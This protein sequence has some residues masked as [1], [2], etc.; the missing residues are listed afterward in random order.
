MYKTVTA[1]SV[2]TFRYDPPM[3]VIAIRHTINFR[4]IAHLRSSEAVG[5]DMFRRGLRV[6]SAAKLELS[7]NPRRVDTG[8]LRSSIATRRIVRD[9]LPGARI[10]TNVNYACIL[11]GHTSVVTDQGMTTIGQIKPGDMVMTQS[12][13]FRRVLAVHSFPVEEKPDLVHIEAPYRNGRIHKLTVTR[14]HKMLVMRDGRYKW[15]HANDLRMTDLLQVRRK[16]SHNEGTAPIKQCEYCRKTHTRQ[17][18]RFCS[19]KCRDQYW[20]AEGHWMLGR[21]RGEEFSRSQSE[22]RKRLYAEKPELHPNRRQ[23]RPTS[24][25]MSVGIWLIMRDLAYERIYVDGIWPD[26]Y[27]E[28]EHRIYEADGAYWHRDQQRDIE[29]DKKLLAAMP[30][31]EIVHMHFY[32]ARHSPDLDPNP[33]PGVWYVVVNPTADSYVEPTAFQGVRP[34]RIVHYEWK[35]HGKP[36]GRRPKLYDL[37]VEGEH[38]FLASG[39]LVSN[40]YIHEGTGIYGPRRRPIRPR[41]KKVL[42]FTVRGQPE[43]VF[44]TSVK[45][46]RPNPYL[47]K[48]L[49]AARY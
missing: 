16:I 22:N 11:G 46:I 4:G 19:R 43:P 28:S 17:G 24:H 8:R 45:G 10:G 6:E 49:R 14:D 47:R 41:R 35:Y 38:S 31:V 26:F 34:L 36:R 21:K 29:R 27:V 7:F 48:A 39:I 5:R 33:L 42:R 12:G 30:G 32:D 13:G 18:K 37:T 15:V 1:C 25:E 9:G 20:R 2:P 44:A 3:A 40:S 23:K